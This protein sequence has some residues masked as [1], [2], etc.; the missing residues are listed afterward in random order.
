MRARV[1]GRTLTMGSDRST[2]D[3]VDGSTAAARATAARVLDRGFAGPTC[4]VFT[5]A[6][7]LIPSLSCMNKRLLGPFRQSIGSTWTSAFA[8]RRL[9]EVTQKPGRRPDREI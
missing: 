3:T 6:T 5:A 1:S 2:L 8:R 4:G 7:S 9:S